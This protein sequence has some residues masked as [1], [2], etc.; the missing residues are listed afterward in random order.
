M[1][2]RAKL[3]KEL[4]RISDNLFV[5][6][7]DEYERARQ[8]WNRIVDDEIFAQ[9]CACH[10]WALP[11]P[12]WS[13]R[14]NAAT[15]SGKNN[16]P[17]TVIA[18][19]GSQIYPDR[20]QGTSCYLIN[21]GLIAIDYGLT[22]SCVQIMTEPYV[23]TGCNDG[24]FLASSTDIVNAL[25]EAYE[26]EAGYTYSRQRD[27]MTDASLLLFDGSLI[28]WHLE[29]KDAFFKNC[30]IT[31]YLDTLTALYDSR[32]LHAAY[33]SM[34]RHRE[35]SNLL[36][37]ALCNFE[38]AHTDAYTGIDHVTDSTIM[39]FFLEPGQRSTIF[40]YTGSLRLSYTQ[41]LRPHFFYINTGYEIGRVEVPAWIAQ[42]TTA[43]D[44]IARVL[45]DQAYKGHGY[46]IALAEAHEQAVIKG[47]DR[48]FFYQVI[49][50]YA[51]QQKKRIEL[52][53]KSMKKR[54]IGV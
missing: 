26:F 7:S 54:L 22:S 18:V 52:S 49:M 3:F 13:G 51:L 41:P 36:R 20:H 19:D 12:S 50:K 15:D 9:K 39:N 24:S 8:V 5:S 10:A 31:R 11:I 53:P 47:P 16:A 2:D 21:I 27:G 1:L 46:P 35:V 43:C 42:S 25:R 28:F 45:L 32:I 23:F 30:F 44:F 6:Y 37:L 17:Y 14:L 38:C 33:V 4:T 29:L 40:G 34:P 48:D